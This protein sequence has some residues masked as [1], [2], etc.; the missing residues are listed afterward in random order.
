MRH[1]M[2]SIFTFIILTITSINIASSQSKLEYDLKVGDTFK[3]QQTANQDIVQEMTGS[4]HEMTNVIKGDYTFVVEDVNDSLFKIKFRFDYFKMSTTSNLLGEILSV[5]TSDEVAEDDIQGKIFAELIKTDLYM[6]MYRDGKIKSVE[7][8]EQLINNMV[9]AAGEFDDFT[10]ELMK[11]SVRSEFGNE[12]LAESFEQM[13]YIYSNTPVK[14]GDSWTNKFEGDLSA[15]NIWTLDKTVD[16][17]AIISC[18]SEVVFKTNDNDIEMNLKGD[19][20]SN[21][22][23]SLNTGFIKTMTNT[24]TYS[25]MSIM[26]EMQVPTSITSNVDYKIEKN[27][28]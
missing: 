27:V 20:T 13:T 10:K 8:T 24:S 18:E 9:D 22:V 17:D 25:G 7:G 26:N 6:N 19:M 3:V 14:T 16:D 1:T 15:N 11:E 23:V 28:Q 4:T 21:L 2:K 5:D 12:S